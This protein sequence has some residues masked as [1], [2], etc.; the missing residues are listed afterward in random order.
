MFDC[1]RPGYML[2]LHASNEGQPQTSDLSTLTSSTI[3]NTLNIKDS[4]EVASCYVVCEEESKA[5]SHLGFR[6]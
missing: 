5:A 3:L 4:E 6:I 1:Y 2:W